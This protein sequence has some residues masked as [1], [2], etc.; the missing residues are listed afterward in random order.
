[1]IEEVGIDENKEKKKSCPDTYTRNLF[2]PLLTGS[3][4]EGGGSFGFNVRSEKKR[5]FIIITRSIPYGTRE[6]GS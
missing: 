6:E 2:M 5:P 3:W 4:K 1:L